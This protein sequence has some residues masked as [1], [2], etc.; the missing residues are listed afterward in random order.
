MALS[1]RVTIAL[2]ACLLAVNYIARYPRTPHEMGVDAFIFHGMTADLV[3]HGYA[4]WVVHPL[5]Y[6][7]LYPLSHPSGSL[8]VLASLSESSGISIEGA[9]LPFG[10]ILVAVGLCAGFF[11]GM[12]IRRD[13]VFGIFVAAIFSLSPR[14]VADTIWQIPT[15][16]FFTTLVPVFLLSI[17]RWHKM[18]E[19]R[20]LIILV[21]AFLCM[22]SAHR[23][24]VLMVAILL[25]FIFTI[26]IAVT[27]KTLRIRYGSRVLSK[28]FRKVANISAITVFFILCGG[29]L[30]LGGVLGDYEQGQVSIGSGIVSQLS[31]FGVSLA[32][33]A[34]ILVVLVPLGVIAMYRTRSRGIPE[35]F[36]LMAMLVLLPTLSLRQ[37]TG[38]YII[39]F[40]A[41]FVAM[42]LLSIL[43]RCS[44]PTSRIALVAVAVAATLGTAQF[45]VA[46]DLDFHAYLDDQTYTDG[47][48]VKYATNGTIIANDGFTASKIF[49]I[50]GKPCLPVGGATT[51]FQSP[52]LLIFGFLDREHLALSRIPL[53]QLTVESDS[54]FSLDGVNA[55][56]DWASILFSPYTSN[57]SRL[58]EAYHLA[59]A[60][61]DHRLLGSFTAYGNVYYSAYF[62][63]LH[64]ST[65]R[66]YADAEVSIW[67]VGG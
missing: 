35:W 1:P 61:E 57:G 48:Y 59:Y 40:T 10:M 21:A 58:S 43:R 30:V 36:F 47:L 20:W 41:V 5:S 27:A 45:V 14:L 62:T 25:A 12:E 66:V 19:M 37:Y 32:R 2:L 6:F 31:N 55:A 28:Q 29:L 22:M 8:F 60:I 34:G 15:R 46:Y 49:A 54:I 51:G 16:T 64:E 11:L 23:L 50:S 24:T 52:E 17:L 18:R 9:I 33:S 63:S 44:T 7:G 56:A 65:Y 4:R 39:P 38:Y 13:A 53:E 3:A 42:A 26:F 67:Y